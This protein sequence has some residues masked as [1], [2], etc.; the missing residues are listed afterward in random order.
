MIKKKVLAVDDDP[1]VLDT[2]KIILSR[3]G[4]E[5]V[6]IRNPNALFRTLD[7]EEFDLVLLDMNFEAKVMTG[8]EGFFWLDEI[9]RKD[10][11]MQVIMITAYGDYELVVRAMK[12]GAFD[13]VVKPWENEKLISTINA[14]CILR[15]TR[16]E[17]NHA[18]RKNDQLMKETQRTTGELVGNSPKMQTLKK[19]IEKVA[20]TDANVLVFGENGTGKELVARKIHKLSGR[21]DKVFINVDLGSLNE[22]LFESEL[23]GHKKGAFT[24]AFEDKS[25]RF[26]IASGGTLFLDEIG[27]IP[28]SLQSKLLGALQNHEVSPVGSNETYSFD[29]RL[30]SATNKDLLQEIGVGTFRED[31]FYRLNTIMIQV[32]PLRER[33]DDILYLAEYFLNLFTGRYNKPHLKYKQSLPDKLLQYKWPGNVRELMHAV[34][35]AVILSSGDVLTEDDFMLENQRRPVGDHHWPL[36]FKDIERQA[37]IRALKNNNQSIVNAAREL[38]LTRQ[39]LFN[40]CKKYGITY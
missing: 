6:G 37:I 22:N 26:E 7:S 28:L 16:K 13:F 15:Q 30:I 31:L 35:K 23:F 2:L 18:C 29:I 21:S 20:P 34:E 24:D 27:N 3:E 4:M 14:A 40:K 9:L 32:P 25:G 39:T 11:D 38:G 12:E 8:N 19:T 17:L 10:P 1:S 33:G 36:K 5:V